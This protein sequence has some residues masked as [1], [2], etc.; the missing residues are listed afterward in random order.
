MAQAL[1]WMALGMGMLYIAICFGK[2]AAKNGKN[3]ILWGILSILSPVNLIILG[4]WAFSKNK[5]GN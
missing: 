3:P 1:G 4:I 2:I 5:S